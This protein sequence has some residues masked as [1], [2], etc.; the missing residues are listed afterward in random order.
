MHKIYPWVLQFT[1]NYKTADQFTAY[2]IPDV[3]TSLRDSTLSMCAGDFLEVYTEQG[4][5]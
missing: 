4:T 5:R 2:T 3:D 1:N